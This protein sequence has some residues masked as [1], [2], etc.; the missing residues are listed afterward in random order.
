MSVKN[1]NQELEYCKDEKNQIDIE[2]EKLKPRQPEIEKMKKL[3]SKSKHKKEA[4]TN[5]IEHQKS[6]LKHIT[7][8]YT[9][10]R[11]S[12]KRIYNDIVDKKGKIRVYIRIRPLPGPV[13]LNTKKLENT[14]KTQNDTII[15]HKYKRGKTKEYKFDKIYNQETTQNEVFQDTKDLIQLVLDGQNVS[16]F[17]YGQKGSGKTHTIYGS[18]EEPGLTLNVIRHLFECINRDNLMNYSVSCF[19]LD[20]Y[21]DSFT[22]LLSHHARPF[23]FTLNLIIIKN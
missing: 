2:L 9:Q 17:A 5:K 15:E 21:H 19:M 22:D 20:L 16:I 12:R 7:E 18:D 1:L 11:A 6:K 8:V 4:L 23:N 14:L 13:K 10:E 3:K